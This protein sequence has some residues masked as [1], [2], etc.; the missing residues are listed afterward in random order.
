MEESLRVTFLPLGVSAAVEPGAP[1]LEAAQRAGVG[2]AADC[3]GSGS[4][5]RCR[6]RA[7]AGAALSPPTP[8][9][10]QVLPPGE[11]AAGCR[12][13]CQACVLAPL[14][15]TVPGESAVPSQ[16]LQ[17]AGEAGGGEFDPPTAICHP[18]LPEAS[19][20]APLTA[21]ERLVAGLGAFGLAAPEPP[22]LSVLRALGGLASPA[23]GRITAGL[24]GDSVCWVLPHGRRILGLAVDL[25]STKVAASLTDMQSGQ[26]LA[27]GGMMNAQ[28]AYGEDVMSRIAA[29]MEK[30]S[31][32]AE[33]CRAAVSVVNRL[34]A[35]LCAAASGGQE[36]DEAFSPDQITECVIVGNTVM[37]HLLLG[38][39]VAQ[40]G[41]APF[42]P[43][44]RE[45]LDCTAGE[46]GL[47]LNPNA[48]VHF[49][50]NLSGFIGSD[51]LAMLL[52]SGAL[53]G[54]G[55]TV[56]IDIGTNSEISLI[57]GG[58]V[59]TCS[60]S[61]GPAFEGA[62]IACGMRAADG[63]IERVRIR[64]GRI[65]WRTVGGGPAVGF[66]GS[67]LLDAVAELKR[68]GIINRH[69]AF[70][71]TCPLVRRGGNGPEVVVCP[72]AETRFGKDLALSRKD[73]G[74]IQLAKAAIRCGLELL[75]REAGVDLETVGRFI[76]AGAFGTYL[77]LESAQAI[78]MFPT[79][80]FE[81]FRQVG[82]AA[83]MGA[84]QLLVSGRLRQTA[85]ELG[86]RMR[87]CELTGRPDFQAE[88]IKALWL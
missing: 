29:S 3:G 39:D 82:N 58:A 20:P 5:G 9:E 52:A 85:R 65:T 88:F 27:E 30:E 54:E 57:A 64:A 61:S 7:E 25:G 68:E 87:H 11:L 77:D 43:V 56:A 49:P 40:L 45:A 67:G 76:V 34:A 53:D 84:R 79:L 23:V 6:V 55:T 48:G 24:R 63:A 70:D 50:P 81:R 16:R 73:I 18:A 62:H 80:P 8:V 10:E 1:L 15:V 38:L 2:L 42:A 66:C 41:L 26:V 31:A 35:E 28:I 75:S 60:A 78:G 74:R 22:R 21:W 44:V 4:C 59:T 19:E 14:T 86:R 69:G 13:A 36:A 32:R 47:A 37:H 83:A 33:L 17:L 12:L 46:L 51:H 71:S 72:A